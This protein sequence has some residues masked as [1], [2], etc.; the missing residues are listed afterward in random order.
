MKRRR[1]PFIFVA[2]PTMDRRVLA[3]LSDAPS[4]NSSIDL[5]A[6]RRFGSLRRRCASEGPLARR[7]SSPATHARY[8]GESKRAPATVLPSPR[9]RSAGPPSCSALEA[10][11]PVRCRSSRQTDAPAGGA[12]P[13]FRPVGKN[14]MTDS[15][16]S[17]RIEDL[18]LA[19]LRSAA[20][21]DD[22]LQLACNGCNRAFCASASQKASSAN[23]LFGP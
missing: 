11:L 15:P 4:A 2:D 20:L 21:G 23:P 19:S 18:D 14:E 6:S 1:K 3:P 16:K 10:A 22:A 8:F 12:Q 9:C 5:G 7:R 13:R 17:S